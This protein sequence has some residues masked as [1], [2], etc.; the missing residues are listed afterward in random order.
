M[1]IRKKKKKQIRLRLPFQRQI[2]RWRRWRR[3][4]RVD[5]THHTWAINQQTD[6]DTEY[7]AES[8]TISSSFSLFSLL[9]LFINSETLKLQSG[10]LPLSWLPYR[11]R[12]M[13]SRVYNFIKPGDLIKI[14]IRANIS[15]SRP[16]LSHSHRALAGIT[17]REYC[18]ALMC[19]CRW[20]C[21]CMQE[22]IFW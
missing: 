15:F 5:K 19:C 20:I 12:S 4:R 1:Q 7:T 10:L 11:P 2:W 21:V 18:L 13:K 22:L 9:V 17:H 3:W 6:A 8:D 14:T 16:H